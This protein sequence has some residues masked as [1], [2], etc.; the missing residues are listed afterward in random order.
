[1]SQE[2][3]ISVEETVENQNAET[4]QTFGGIFVS[5]DF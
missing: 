4:A 5:F 1:M 3:E 2:Q